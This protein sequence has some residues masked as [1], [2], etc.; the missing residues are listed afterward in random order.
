MSLR[1]AALVMLLV[2]IMPFLAHSVTDFSPNAW[3]DNI[4]LQAR[5]STVNEYDIQELAYKCKKFYVQKDSDL[6]YIHIESPY[7]NPLVFE[8]TYSTHTPLRDGN[9]VEYVSSFKVTRDTLESSDNPNAIAA[10]NS[11]DAAIVYFTVDLMLDIT[12]QHQM[13]AMYSIIVIVMVIV[14]LF[15][16]TG[17]FNSAVK[18]LVVQP[19]EKML[20]TLRQSAMVMLNTMSALEKHNKQDDDE[21]KEEEEEDDGEMESAM[22]EKMVGKLAKMLKH[23]LPGNAEIVCDENIDKSTAAWLN[24]AY[25]G[26]GNQIRDVKKN[27]ELTGKDEE[28]RLAELKSQQNVVNTDVLNSWDFDV[29]DYSDSDLI[30]VMTYTFTILNVLP[31][32]N[33]PQAVFQN[34]LAEISSRYITSNTYHNFKHGCDVCH[35]TYRL[36]M[37]TQLN[38]ILSPLEVISS[39]LVLFFHYS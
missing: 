16:F 27:K 28:Q 1:V 39:V 4:R 3:L 36:M 35:T 22:L 11:T 31:E 26:G 6:R 9:V 32:F 2:I 37:I 23:V 10:A 24:E 19:L 33:V 8:E 34:F 20:K 30:E 18:S 12:Y 25:S 14:I 17:S 5:N 38:S 7:V 21:D 13:D 29:L 15:V